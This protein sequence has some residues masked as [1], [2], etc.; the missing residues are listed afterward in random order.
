MKTRSV[1]FLLTAALVFYFVVLG[2]RAII[3]IRDGRPAFVLLGIGVLL[4]P[5]VG[6]WTTWRELQLGFASQRLGQQVGDGEV[7]FDSAKRA[8]EASPEDW[9][10]WY[11]LAMAYG[12][13]RDTKNGR[14][15]MKQAVELEAK[16]RESKRS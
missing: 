7:D 1:A 15:A 9:R 13:E 10:A 5:I 6:A 4:L 11:R 2:E 16:E 14:A 8:V 3:M 12:A